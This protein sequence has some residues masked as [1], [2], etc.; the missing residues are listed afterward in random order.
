MGE[1]LVAV[2]DDLMVGCSGDLTG[3]VSD[4]LV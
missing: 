4:W 1:Q 2:M 3:W